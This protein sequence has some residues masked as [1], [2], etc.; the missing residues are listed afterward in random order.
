MAEF[1]GKQL[2]GNC[3][4]GDI[5]SCRIALNNQADINYLDKEMKGAAWHAINGGH[6]ELVRFLMQKGV[7][8]SVQDINGNSLMHL[9]CEKKNKYI[10]LFLLQ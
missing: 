1:F 8:T 7:D 4:N 9:A 2:I 5:A 6:T 10:V 3:T